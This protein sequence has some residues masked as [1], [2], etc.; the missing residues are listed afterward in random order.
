MA[1]ARQRRGL[2]EARRKGVREE[3][4]GIKKLISLFCFDRVEEQVLIVE[5][6]VCQRRGRLHAYA[7]DLAFGVK[8]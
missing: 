2:R 3:L 5:A 4:L 8:L 1:S 6:E 7:I